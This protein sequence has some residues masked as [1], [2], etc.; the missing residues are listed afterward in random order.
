MLEPLADHLGHTGTH[1][2]AVE[3]VGDLHGAFLVRDDQ[4]LALLPQLLEERN[5]AAEVDVVQGGLDL[6]HDVEGRGPGAEDRAE[7]GHRG[8]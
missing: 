7:H 8:Q 3:G 6:V 2:D 4:Q 5:Q 1:G